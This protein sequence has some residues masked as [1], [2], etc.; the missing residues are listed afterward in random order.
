MPTTKKELLWSTT[1][2][3]MNYKIEFDIMVTNKNINKYVNVF[4]MTSTGKTCCNIGDRMPLFTLDSKGKFYF[5][6]NLNEKGNECMQVG[7]SVG[8]THHVEIVQ[9]AYIFAIKVDGDTK[10]MLMNESPQNFPSA[11]F[12]LFDSYAPYAELSNLKITLPEKQTGPTEYIPGT[13]GGP[14]TAE[15]I[16]IVR[17]RIFQFIN[18]TSEAK[19]E[20]FG[21]RRVKHGSDGPIS[22]NTL[23]RLAFHDCLRYNDTTGGCDGC[24]NWDGMGFRFRK[25]DFRYQPQDK[26]DNN[27]LARLVYYLEKIYITKDWPLEAPSLPLSLKESGKSRADLW[28]FAGLVA[29]ERSIERANWACDYDFNARQQITLLEGREKCDIK[30][31]KPIKFQYG[32]KDCVTTNALPFIASKHEEHPSKHDAIQI[33]ELMKRDFGMSA[34]HFIALS[35]IHSIA[36]NIDTTTVGTKYAWFGAAYLNN[37]YYKMI[38]NKPTYVFDRGGDITFVGGTNKDGHLGWVY[39]DYSVGNRAGEPV[40]ATGWRVSCLEAWDTEEGGPCF[41]RPTSKSHKDNPIYKT[42]KSNWPVDPCVET[43]GQPEGLGPMTILD[44]NGLPKIKKGHICKGATVD[45]NAVRIGG[46]SWGGQEW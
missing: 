24:L 46:H 10:V 25:W 2:W 34:R 17:E 19:K 36:S 33:F 5:C 3:G 9:I 43:N 40:A 32:R 14:W 11:K 45:Q 16:D 29:L 7:R 13:P 6:T 41:F 35:G 31:T 28:A 44:E 23:I 20:M 21:G 15:E 27:D 42:D 22:E 26:T 8:Q 39:R 37:K 1:D 18:P 4:H 38:A 12:F 30:L